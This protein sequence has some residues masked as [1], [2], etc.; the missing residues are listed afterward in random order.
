VLQFPSLKCDMPVTPLVLLFH[1]TI[2]GFQPFQTPTTPRNL[3]G[4][5][6]FYVESI[7]NPQG[8]HMFWVKQDTLQSCGFLMES[9]EW[10]Y[11][12][13]G[14]ALWNPQNGLME[15]AECEESMRN[16]WESVKPSPYLTMVLDPPDSKHLL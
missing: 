16:R 14:M 2:P 6:T 7:G 9:V 1:C 10:P 4:I 11:G 8:I 5:L 3:H 15:S 12:I 13:H